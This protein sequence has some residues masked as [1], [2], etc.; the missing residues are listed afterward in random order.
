MNATSP[1]E[2]VQTFAATIVQA[3]IFAKHGEEALIRFCNPFK[4]YADVRARVDNHF[5]GRL[6]AAKMCVGLKHKGTKSLQAFVCS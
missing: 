4:N 6:K 2:P 3:Y 1:K 5:N